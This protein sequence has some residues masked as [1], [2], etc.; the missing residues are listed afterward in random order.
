MKDEQY[1][2]HCCVDQ[3]SHY[4]IITQYH[5]ILLNST[6]D[7]LWCMPLKDIQIE[8]DEEEMRILNQKESKLVLFNDKE[9]CSRLYGILINIPNWTNKEIVQCSQ[10]L[11]RFINSRCKYLNYNIIHRF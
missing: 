2:F 10:E 1:V 11:I 4:F 6:C 8:V 3:N 9:I 5:C 7:L